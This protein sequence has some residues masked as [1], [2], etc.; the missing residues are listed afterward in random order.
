MG[1]FHSTKNSEIEWNGKVLE[2]VFEI[3]GTRCELTLFDRTE[4]NGGPYT[5]SVPMFS[6]WVCQDFSL[7]LH[8]QCNLFSLTTNGILQLFL[9]FCSKYTSSFTSSSAILQV[10]HQCNFGHE[11]YYYHSYSDNL[12]S[13]IRMSW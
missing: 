13:T 7:F 9:L 5:I 12:E 6:L 3:L 1:A 4:N 11:D 8:H 2:N 10:S